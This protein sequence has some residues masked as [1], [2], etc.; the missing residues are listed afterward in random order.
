FPAS[1]RVMAHRASQQLEPYGK[2]I[3]DA[4]GFYL[5]HL[6]TERGSIPVRQAVDELIANRQAAGLS[7]V[8]LRGL[9][10]RLGRF[11]E[12]FG[13]RS[14]ASI[15]T[16][17]IVAWLESLGVGAVTRNTFRRDVRTLFSFCLHHRYCAA[18]P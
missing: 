16:R 5:K 14:V 11:S 8:Y 13:E 6:Q 18:N 7:S 4:V 9:Q 17:E 15:S 2:S 3:D 10:Y 12:S 1:L